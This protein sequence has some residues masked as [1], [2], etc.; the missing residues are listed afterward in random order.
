MLLN[1]FF[2]ELTRS[3]SR[4]HFSLNHGCF[5]ASLSKILSVG[6]IYSSLSSKS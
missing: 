5:S 1:E 4:I 2:F 6:F 3:Q